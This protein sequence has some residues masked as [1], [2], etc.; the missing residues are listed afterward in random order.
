MIQ[1]ILPPKGF[2]GEG[3]WLIDDKGE[4]YLDAFNS[5]IERRAKGKVILTM[6]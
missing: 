4:R 5:I 3:S 6:D 2:P 1:K